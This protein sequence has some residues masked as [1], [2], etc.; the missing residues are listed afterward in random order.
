MF[1][2]RFL[3]YQKINLDISQSIM[4]VTIKLVLVV[5]VKYLYN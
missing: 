2:D 4:F 5:P 1:N 3:F